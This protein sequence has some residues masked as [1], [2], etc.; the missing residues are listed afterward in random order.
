MK[1]LLTAALMLALIPCAAQAKNWTITQRQDAQRKMIDAAQKSNELT[2]KEADAL[3]HRLDKIQTAEIKMKS[4][5]GGQL[6][7]KDKAKLEKDLNGVSLRIQK[8]KLKKRVIK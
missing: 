6:S 3:R 2:L 8:Y 5:N 1:R 4:A 7:Y